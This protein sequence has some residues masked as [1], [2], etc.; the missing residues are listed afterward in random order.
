MNLIVLLLLYPIVFLFGVT[1]HLPLLIG[2]LKLPFAVALFI[3]NMV[4]VAMTG[5]LVPLVAARFGWWL[6]PTGKTRNATLL[7][8][9]II[10]ALY[11][12]CILAFLK[13]F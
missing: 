12:G 6:Q 4:S 5:F 7:G 1:V 13:F 2:L 11:A 3:G 8:T 10:V 9:T